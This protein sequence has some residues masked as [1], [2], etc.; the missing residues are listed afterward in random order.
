MDYL[1]SKFEERPKVFLSGS[2]FGG[3][4]ALK[5][6]LLDSSRYAGVVLLAPALRDVCQSKKY[7]KKL[8]SLLTW[9]IPRW[10]IP[11]SSSSKEVT[12][13][14]CDELIRNDPYY[15]KSGLVPASISAVLDAMEQVS[16]QYSSFAL[17]F[18]VLQGGHDKSVDLFAPLD[19]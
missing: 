15:C 4:I 3:T 14:N 6:G 18:I 7:L 16:G 9:I 12:K 8:N 19:L 10:H 1:L 5:M 2:S 13:H 17:P 11:V